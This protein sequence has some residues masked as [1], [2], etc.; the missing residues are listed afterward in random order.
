MTN[1]KL[2]NKINLLKQYAGNKGESVAK[3]YYVTLHKILKKRECV[4][5]EKLRFYVVESLTLF[6]KYSQGTPS[7]MSNAIVE[8]RTS[9]HGESEFSLSITKEVLE[10]YRNRPVWWV[11]KRIIEEI[12]KK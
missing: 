4:D 6:A 8:I 11:K 10:L 9:H 2:M 5:K 3:T 1:E 7:S 12:A